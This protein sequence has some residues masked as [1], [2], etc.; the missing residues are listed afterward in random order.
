MIF[1]VVYFFLLYVQHSQIKHNNNN[2]GNVL[3]KNIGLMKLS[4]CF[5][6]SDVCMCVNVYVLYE[7]LIQFFYSVLFFSVSYGTIWLF[8][9]WNLVF[10]S[11]VFS[12]SSFILFYF[13][14]FFKLNN[15]FIFTN[16][17]EPQ[18][19]QCGCEWGA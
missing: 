2:I 3:I 6:F 7:E 12:S 18:I 8:H 15:Q 4:L 5:I 10:R 16:P 9:K 11:I 19:T 14:S 13:I 17:D 1:C